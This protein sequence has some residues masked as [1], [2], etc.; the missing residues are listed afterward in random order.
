MHTQQN[1][2]RLINKCY[3]YTLNENIT[4]CIMVK[5]ISS[6]TNPLIKKIALLNDKAKLRK[7]TESFVVEGKKEIHMAI[8]GGYIPSVVLF[9]PTISTYNQ[10]YGLYGEVL[11]TT[12][13]IEVTNL[14]YNKIAYRESTEGVMAVFK[15]R[16]TAL[17]DLAFNSKSPLV[18]VAESPEKPGNIGA[19]LRTADA[20]GVDAVIIA[21]PTTDLFN[22]N[23][24]RSSVGT[25]F[26][27][28]VA[29]GS[30]EDVIAYLKSQK[31]Q[32]VCA[33]LTEDAESCYKMNFKTPSAI[34]VGTESL[35]LSDIW[36]NSADNNVM[37]PMFGKVDSMNV[38]VSAA[39][40]L[41]EAVRQRTH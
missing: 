28:Q 15:Q 7:E 19:L 39:I 21:N 3:F 25:L 17:N 18:L 9:N 26:T 38:S 5:T 2:K 6:P 20:A 14:V 33:T 13:M 35:G 8:K 36:T 40:L 22:P 1:R 32:I 27:T 29:T 31:L 41:F 24:I 11:F 30:T 37:I 23:I 16:N 4:F 34:V 12:E 10:L